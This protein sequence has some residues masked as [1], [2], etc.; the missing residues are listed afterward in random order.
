MIRSFVLFCLRFFKSRIQLQLEIVF[1]RKQL[2]ILARTSAKPRLTPSDRFFFSIL[3]G[4]FSAWK[5]SLLIIKPE[6]VIRWH[7]QG[8]RLYWRWKSRS[9]LGRPKIPQAQINL[10]KQM[11][12]ENPLWGAPRIHGEILKL[13]FDISEA[14]V[15]RYMPR[16]R[17]RTTRQRWKTFLKNHSAETISLDFF[18]VPTI[19]FKLLHVLVFLSHDR[20]KI[21]H[22]NVT[23][24]PTSER[25]TQQLRNAFC[26]E[27]PPK[28]L[29]RDR[30]GKF[31]EVFSN[32]VSALGIRPILTAYRSPWQNGH[33]ERV[34]GSIRRE[35]LDHMII[36]NESH[37]RKSLKRYFHYYNTQRTH[38]G[39]N[40]DSPEPRQVQA[41]GGIDKVTVANGLHHFYFRK[42]A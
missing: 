25:T 34:I 19:T 42:A 18:V 26:D 38:L 3:T 12:S 7:R 37:L 20:R 10:I 40:K 27:E 32:C 15:Q 8:F 36:A 14:T 31:G 33:V 39:V 24:H 4:I 28:F 23:D 11:A 35:C 21:I 13:G 29:I 22:F 16:K 30:D 5:G 41:E 1:L 9:A 2:E 17:Q 6:T